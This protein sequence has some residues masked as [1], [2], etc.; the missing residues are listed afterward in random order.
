MRYLLVLL[1]LLSSTA[2]AYETTVEINLSQCGKKECFAIFQ[3]NIVVNKDLEVLFWSDVAD[4]FFKGHPKF[5]PLLNI[6]NHTRATMN[7]HIEVELQDIHKAS[8]G[9]SSMDTEIIPHSKIKSQYDIYRSINAIDMPNGISD[10]AK[11][12]RLS[13]AI[14]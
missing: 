11:Y 9:S 14:K 2:Y 1:F 3:K 5:Y 4:P 7:L 12:V 10:K 13:V 6:F 8:L